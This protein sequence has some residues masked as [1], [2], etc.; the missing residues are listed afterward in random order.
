MKKVYAK[1]N[2]AQEIQDRIFR[3]MDADKKL[4]ITLEI[5]ALC[6]KLNRLGNN[7]FSKTTHKNRK[8]FRK[9]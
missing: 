9:A 8:D 7:G 3:S 2:K 1:S 6:L 4:K 5:S